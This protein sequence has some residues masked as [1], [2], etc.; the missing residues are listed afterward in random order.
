MC[1]RDRQLLVAR[2]INKDIYYIPGGKRELGE[3]DHAALI[4]EIK[5]ELSVDLLPETIEYAG[6]FTAQAH[7]KPLGTEVNIRCYFADFTGELSANSE[8]EAISWIHY[9]DK[10]KVSDVTH[11]IMD[12]LQSLGKIN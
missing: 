8:I 12:W 1:I 11:Q 10:N 3:T 5:E 9:R 2:S 7:G 6:I 4:R